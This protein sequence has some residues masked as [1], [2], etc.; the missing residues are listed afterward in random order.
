M[1]STASSSQFERDAPDHDSEARAA[2]DRAVRDFDAGA[3]TSRRANL[4]EAIVYESRRVADDEA[5]IAADVSR[6]LS[7]LIDRFAALY[8]GDLPNHASYREARST[9]NELFF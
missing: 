9:L 2:F 6:V 4:I 8:S 5:P 7:D 1:S 3:S